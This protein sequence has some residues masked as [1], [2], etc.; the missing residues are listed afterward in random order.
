MIFWFAPQVIRM[1][2]MVDSDVCFTSTFLLSSCLHLKLSVLTLVQPTREHPTL[3]GIYVTNIFLFF[4][5]QL[6]WCMAK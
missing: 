6:R 3:H 2:Y 1:T 4:F 5:F